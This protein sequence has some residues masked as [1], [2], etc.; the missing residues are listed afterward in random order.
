MTAGRKFSA[1]A[2]MRCAKAGIL[3]VFGLLLNTHRSPPPRVK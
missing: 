1:G 2:A 3:I